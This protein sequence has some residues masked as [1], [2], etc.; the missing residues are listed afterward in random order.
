MNIFVNNCPECGKTLDGVFNPYSKEWLCSEH[1]KTGV[2]HAERGCIVKFAHPDYG[3]SFDQEV[4]AKYLT[5]GA[6]Y[7]VKSVNIGQSRSMI[8][9]KEFPGKI[10][11]TV[12]FERVK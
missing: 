2:L 3:S 10:F 9:L 5:V 12:Q 7:T 1:E 11:N 6:N 4:A 8:E